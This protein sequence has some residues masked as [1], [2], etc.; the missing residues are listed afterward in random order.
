MGQDVLPMPVYV[1]PDG[2]WYQRVGATAI[3]T[4]P[5]VSVTITRM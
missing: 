2:Y 1:V 5:D 4:W 3:Y